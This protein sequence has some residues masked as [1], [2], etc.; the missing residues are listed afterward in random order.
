MVPGGNISL[1]LSRP[2]FSVQVADDVRTNRYDPVHYRRLGR[3]RKSP[4]VP[5]AFLRPIKPDPVTDCP[6]VVFDRQ[7]EI[8]AVGAR[9]A[10]S[11][12][13]SLSH[14]TTSRSYPGKLRDDL[15]IYICIRHGYSRIGFSISKCSLDT[16]NLI[17]AVTCMYIRASL[18]YICVLRS[19]SSVQLQNKLGSLQLIRR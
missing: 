7:T 2:S 11:T 10:R 8:R 4:L 15:Y 1:S 17:S 3:S 9:S 14:D 13:A 16:R 18:R 12:F 19:H 6:R 5:R